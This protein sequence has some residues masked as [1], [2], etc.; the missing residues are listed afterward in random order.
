M[1]LQSRDLLGCF[2]LTEPDFGSNPAGMITNYKDKVGQHI[3]YDKGTPLAKVKP[4]DVWSV[5]T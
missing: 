4:D 3:K 2:G 1:R 5:S